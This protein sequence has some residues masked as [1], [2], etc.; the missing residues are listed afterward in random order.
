MGHR[1][2]HYFAAGITNRASAATGAIAGATRQG[3]DTAD[4]RGGYSG[5]AGSKPDVLDEVVH[6]PATSPYTQED[7]AQKVEQ[8][9]EAHTVLQQ[10]IAQVLQDALQAAKVGGAGGADVATARHT[11]MLVMPYAVH[12]LL[13]HTHTHSC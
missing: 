13:S 9:R 12:T 4:D 11:K 10:A 8:A 6:A 1:A 7:L 3:G 2:G 5:A